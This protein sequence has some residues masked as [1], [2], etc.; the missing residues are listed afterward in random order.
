LPE[1]EAKWEGEHEIQLLYC[2]HFDLEDMVNFNRG[3]IDTNNN[4]MKPKN[5]NSQT[6]KKVKRS[7]KIGQRP[8]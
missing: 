7:T 6:M 5:K 2:H 3:G 4:I 1:E 8:K